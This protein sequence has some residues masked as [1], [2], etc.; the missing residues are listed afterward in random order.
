MAS[1]ESFCKNLVD[2]FRQAALG[3]MPSDYLLKFEL[4]WSP[5]TENDSLTY[6]EFISEYSNMIDLI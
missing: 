1:H 5:Q 2:Y 6:D 4:M 3:S